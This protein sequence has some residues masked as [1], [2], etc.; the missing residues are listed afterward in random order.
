MMTGLKSW[1]QG[2]TPREQRLLLAMLAVAGLVLVWVAVVRPLGDGLAAARERHGA[3]VVALAE[4][5]AQAEQIRLLEQRKPA[6]AAEPLHLL[7]GDAA[8]EAGFQ[9]SRLEP[10]E[11]GAGV[12]VAIESAKP[13]ALFGWVAQMEGARGLIV[14]RLNATAN[15]DRTLAVQVTFRTRGS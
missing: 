9:L 15:A 1:F 5:R 14:E 13:E 2:R 3:A 10:Q 8:G 7:V 12:L 4:A 6:A 11:G